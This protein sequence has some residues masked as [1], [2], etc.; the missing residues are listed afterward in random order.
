[1]TKQQAESAARLAVLAAMDLLRT[2]GCP[3][4]SIHILAAADGDDYTV[5]GLSEKIC[6][7]DLADVLRDTAARLRA[8]RV[9]VTDV[10]GPDGKDGAA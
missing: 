8:G 1:M 10:T 5:Q 2:A 7:H 9:N 6:P 4:F 3:R